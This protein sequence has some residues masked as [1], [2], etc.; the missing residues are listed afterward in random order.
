[1]LVREL[2]AALPTD[3]DASSD[4]LALWLDQ[5]ADLVIGEQL[6]DLSPPVPDG[7]ACR[8]DGR[9]VTESVVDRALTTPA[10]LAAE[11]RLVAWADQ[12]IS[13]CGLDHAVGVAEG[14][15]LP[16]RQAACAV[17]GERELVLVL[18][19]AGTGKTTALAPAVEQLRADGR[20]V[21]GVAPSAAAAEVL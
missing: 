20:A 5:V 3:L 12:R 16:Q 17:A 4:R 18:G 13:A 9:P 2:G 1:E 10:I 6:V 8:R 7:V 21:F 15:T 11:E 14:L 19:P